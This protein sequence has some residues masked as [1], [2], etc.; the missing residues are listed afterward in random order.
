MRD[1]IGR[2]L[3]WGKAVFGISPPDRIASTSPSDGVV[4]LPHIHLRGPSNGVAAALDGDALGL[5]RPYVAASLGRGPVTAAV[6]SRKRGRGA[7]TPVVR[8]WAR[9]ARCVSL[10]RHELR[11]ALVGWE[12]VELADAAEIVLSELLT[13]AVRHVRAPQDRL[14]ETRYE[15]L[16]D[17]V[18]V[19]A[20]RPGRTRRSRGPATCPG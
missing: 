16:E 4:R 18:R 6:I 19:K 10:A 12:L 20:P 5:V 13:N 14:V 17:G 7:E 9:S 3:G 15:R 11:L 1:L 8:R 2:L